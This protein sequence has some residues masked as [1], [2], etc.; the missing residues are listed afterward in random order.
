MYIH[1]VIRRAFQIH[2]MQ[3]MPCNEYAIPRFILYQ[4]G[5]YIPNS[6]IVLFCLVPGLLSI[7]LIVHELRLWSLTGVGF[8]ACADVITGLA[9]L[10]SIDYW[11]DLQEGGLIVVQVCLPLSHQLYGA[12]L[13]Y[14][15]SLGSRVDGLI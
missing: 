6:M 10:M 1:S 3:V 15:F 12:D 13:F 11:Y 9:P 5:L 8:S 7:A 4:Y 2:F 14:D